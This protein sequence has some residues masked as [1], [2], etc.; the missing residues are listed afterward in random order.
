MRA[1][2][3]A[4]VLLLAAAVTAAADQ[5]GDAVMVG[6]PSTVAV[7]RGD[8]ISAIAARFGVSPSAIVERNQL[9]R[10]DV[11]TPGQ[12]LTVDN[13]HIAIVDRTTSITINVAQRML[14]VYEDGRV[15]AHPVTVG[16]RDWPTPLGRFTIVAKEA[17]PAWD[18]PLSIQREMARQGRE[19]ITRM[20]PSPDNPLGTH[21]L[22]LSIPGLGIHG[23]NAPSSI[24]R[25]ASHGCI[26]MHPDHIGTLFDRIAVGTPGVLIYEPVLVAVVDDRVWLEAHP[27]PYRLR[28]NAERHLEAA[29]DRLAIADRIDWTRASAVLRARAGRPEDVTAA[30]NAPK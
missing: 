12:T 29:A 19:V 7:R 30:R 4:C 9:A 10:P 2:I 21:W 22:R 5:P 1:V 20:E 18:V 16:S 6:G 3:G 28:A 23:T 14:F 15:S 11:I 25:Y 8:T 26:R 27:D 17:N 13:S 24:Y